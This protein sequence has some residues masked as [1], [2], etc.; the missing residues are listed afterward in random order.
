M[1][2][3]WSAPVPPFARD[4]VTTGGD[5]GIV[6]DMNL[7]GGEQGEPRCISDLVKHTVAVSL[8]AKAIVRSLP[9]LWG[10]E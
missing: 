3:P 10:A 6:N 7:W 8:G 4:Q 2:G 5:S 1:V 9:K